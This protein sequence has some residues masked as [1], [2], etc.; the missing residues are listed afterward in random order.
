MCL[1]LARCLGFVGLLVIWCFGYLD[2]FAWRF[3]FASF[4]IVVAFCCLLAVVYVCGF[5]C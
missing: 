3:V 2:L 1:G 5:S 4:V